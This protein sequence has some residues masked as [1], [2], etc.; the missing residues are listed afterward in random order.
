M[1]HSVQITGATSVFVPALKLAIE[2]QGEQHYLPLEH[3]GGEQGLKDRQAMDKTKRLACQEADIR[4][5]MRPSKC[6]R[7]TFLTS[8]VSAGKQ[9]IIEHTLR[10]I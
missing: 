10:T 6:A 8:G 5:L 9:A 7:I 4:L 1:E 2:Y 3:W